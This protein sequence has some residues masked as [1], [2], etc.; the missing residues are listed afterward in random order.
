MGR[1]KLISLILVISL[2]VL[3][4]L[5]MAWT[6]PSDI[7]LRNFYEIYNATAINVTDFYQNTYRVLDTNSTLNA[8]NVNGS[9][10]NVNSSTYWDDE[11]SQANL[12]VNSS[13]YW[14]D[15][16]TQ[17]NLSVNN[18]VYWDDETSQANLNVNSSTYWD[19]ETSQANLNVNSSTWWAGITNFLSNTWFYNSANNLTFNETK[20]NTTIEGVITTQE[21]S[22][23]VNS[24][25]YWDNKNTPSDLNNLILSDWA[26]ISNEPTNL[27]E[28]TD[29]LDYSTKNVNSSDYWDDYNTASDLNNLITIQGEN[30]SGGTIDFARLPSLTN[31]VI[32][33]WANITNKFITA[34]AGRYL[35]MSGSTLNLNDT[36][37]NST[38]QFD[39]SA[40][41]SGTEFVKGI[42]PNGTLN[43]TIPAGS[44]DITGVWTNGTYLSGGGASGDL[45]IRFN[46]TA[47]VADWGNWS[48]DQ[49]DYYTSAVV[50]TL[51]NLRADN[52][53]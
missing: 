25:D 34:V 31:L 51:G 12:N 7:D 23:N 20:L 9:E 32:S 1:N 42:L 41:C 3:I 48:A 40:D 38:F 6:P 45:D 47:G 33:D 5:A 49:G 28:F 18:S 17:A 19:D 35:Y 29:D 27:S 52:G 10:L 50:D 8:S 37:L 16:T 36:L 39:V 15:E 21:S 2:L 43:C 24:S 46:T 30:I 11:T 22:L 53:D 13:T 4:P 14:D 26:N 44:G